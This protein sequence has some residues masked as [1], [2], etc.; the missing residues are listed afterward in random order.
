VAARKGCLFRHIRQWGIIPLAWLCVDSFSL[1]MLNWTINQNHDSVYGLY[2]K[3]PGFIPRPGD[4]IFRLSLLIILQFFTYIRHRLFLW[5]PAGGI[6]ISFKMAIRALGPT[7]L[8]IQWRAEFIALL[9]Q[10]SR[11]ETAR[12][13]PPSSQFRRECRDIYKFLCTFTACTETTLRL[14]AFD[15][16]CLWF[17]LVFPS[18]LCNVTSHQTTTTSCTSYPIHDL[19][20][21]RSYK[22]CFTGCL[23]K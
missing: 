2:S 21:F 20:L 7:Q 15:S 22:V 4:Q 12:S 9:V 18:M 1:R 17:S 13:P 5:I 3:N 6:F 11:P 10:L 8:L 23:V 16:E 14:A 19:P